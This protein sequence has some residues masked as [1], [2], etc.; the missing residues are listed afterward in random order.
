MNFTPFK[1]ITTGNVCLAVALMSAGAGLQAEDAQPIFNGKDLS[2]WYGLNPHNLVKVAEDKKKEAIASYQK[3]F[4]DHWTVDQG[5]L[6]NDG[7]GPYATTDK[8]YGDIELELDYK[9]VAKADSGI[10]LRGAPQVQIWDTTEEGGKWKIKANLGSGSL[11]NNSDGAPGKLPLVHADKPFGEWNHFKITQIGAR[12]TVVYNGKLV[13][14]NAIMENYWDKVKKK[15]APQPTPPLPAK[16][17]I[18]LQTHGGEIRWKN[19]NLR[20]IG[21]EEANK[22]LRGS[23]AEQGFVSIFNGKDLTGWRGAVEDYEVKEG[24]VM[25]KAGKGGVLFTAD[26]YE[27]FVVRMEYK[28]PAGGNNGLAIR[29]PGEGRAAYDG[30]CELQVLD[31]DAEKYKTLDKRQFHGSA[32]AMAAAHR[33]YTRPAGEWNY[34]EVTVKGSTIK[35]EVNGTVILNTDLSKVTEFMKD[36]AH[37]GKDRKR[38][39]FG[40]AGHNDPVMFRNI[41]IK[42]L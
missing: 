11:F 14:D 13:V 22:T 20:E 6:V 40:F 26:E 3:E 17:V 7:H 38:G 9:T 16:G 15:D 29:Y 30:M 32:Y 21:G 18:H 25:C 27:D 19:I 23:D 42:R 36:T 2:G 33:G 8:E 5:E 37:P 28:V 35:V 10:Y 39:H 24:A 34:Q 41:A 4:K 1:T 31:N 12:T